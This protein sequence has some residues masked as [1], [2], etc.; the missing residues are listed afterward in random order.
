MFWQGF[1]RRS[2]REA[3]AT[4]SLV[5]ASLQEN[6]SGVR[7]IQSLGREARNS[8]QFDEAN[9]ANLEANLG[10]SR[11]SAAT[12]P[13]VEIIQALALALVVFFGGSM[14]INGQLSTGALVAFTLYVQRFFEPIRMLT[15]EYNMLQR[16]SVAAERIFEILDTK[17]D[18]VDAPDAYELGQLS[19]A[20]TYDNVRF[21]YVE[22]VDIL[23]DFNLEIGAGERV[24]FVG[25]TGAGKSTL[26][27]LLM[28]FY[29]VTGGAI[30]VDGHDLRDV[31]M[32]SLRRQI[33]IVLQEPVLFSGTVAHN[34]RYANPDATDEE[35][36]AAA[37]AVGAH[38]FIEHMEDGYDTIVN[39]RGVGLS[40]GERQLIAFARALLA[41]PRILIL[42]EA[43]ANLDTTTELVVQRGI[44]ELTRGR[45]ALMI[46]H[47]L[48]TIRDADR[49][50]VLE[51]G[52]IVEEGTHDELIAM[53]G[54]YYRLYSLGFQQTAQAATNG[55]G[56]RNGARVRGGGRRPSQAGA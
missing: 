54:T 46:A 43:T 13:I 10:A 55:A 44:R 34:I 50:V 12:M 8:R 11:V 4:I 42:D 7:V 32:Q 28:R 2:F 27:S 35:V 31:T 18:V 22:G 9:T 26:I 40:I 29:D 39:E 30:R 15:Q 52:R 47:R 37:R 5:N 49:I 36:V 21:A 6:V 20:V 33:G 51:H 24:A 3:R 53:H 19:G 38:E 45:T 56:A 23:K 1:A 25:Q 14:V 16:A 41:N 17:S 48:S